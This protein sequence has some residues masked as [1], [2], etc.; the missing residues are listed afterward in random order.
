MAMNKIRRVA[1]V[2][3]GL[4]GLCVAIALRRQGIDVDVFEQA[5]ALGEFGA[6]INVSPNAVR[7]FE[8]MG[9]Q[10]ELREASFQPAGIAWRSL[11]DGSL[12][13]VLPLDDATAR[14]GAPYYVI[15]RSDLHA[16]LA[17]AV[18]SSSLHLNKRCTE[19]ELR[20]RAVGLT[21]AD[22]SSHEADL[23]IGSDGIR[24]AVRKSVFGGS[25]P[26]Y[27]GYMCWRSLVPVEALPRGHQD[28]FVTN[29]GG[30]N[31]FVVSYYVRQGKFVNIV[32]VRRQPDWTEE[33]WS[34]PSTNAE[35]VSAF[36]EVGPQ[37][38]ELLQ[39]ATHCTK[40][41]QFTGEHAPEWTRGR[42]TL[43]G[44]AAHAMLATFAQGAAMAFEDSYVL[45]RWLGEHRDEPERAL[46]GYEA[47][48][49]PRA[50]RIQDLSRT[51]VAFKNISSPIERLKRQWTYLTRFG[52][53]PGS[54]Y[55][56][57]FAYDPVTHW[58]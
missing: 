10:Q 21:F 5:P 35:L 46:A 4:G 41:G 13:K 33:S 30:T 11:A 2:G 36:P 39:H 25:G 34:V 3:A 20:E 56:W 24:S 54:A 57:M 26:R 7:V 27:S 50:T 45:A 17:G 37:V 55:R 19:V 58:Q 43:L 23:V 53:T 28:D 44:D 9:L 42:V 22:G 40:W 38:G 48:R 15:H 29:W 31:G 6:G 32:A 18:P 12:Q 52:S 14:F 8:A 1:V 47:V 49:K 51:E 16:M